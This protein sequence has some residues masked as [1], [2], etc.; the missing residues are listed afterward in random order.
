M[1]LKAK[2]K[3]KHQAEIRAK[4]KAKQQVALRAKQKAANHSSKFKQKDYRFKDE[5]RCG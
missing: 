4:Q 3:A 5:K 1:A 2:Q